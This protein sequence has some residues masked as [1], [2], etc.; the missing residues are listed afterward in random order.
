MKR[1]P[2]KLRVV[3]KF[4]GMNRGEFFLMFCDNLSFVYI[5]T[6]F[7]NRLLIDVNK[8]PQNYRDSGVV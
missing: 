3:S 6:R 2:A 4:I 1:R 7:K 5:E 8:K